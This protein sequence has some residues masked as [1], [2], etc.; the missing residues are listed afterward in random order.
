MLQ[1][2][3]S[4]SLILSTGG[5]HFWE[6]CLNKALKKQIEAAPSLG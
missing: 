4:Y 5:E 6:G 3:F 2:L 1:Y